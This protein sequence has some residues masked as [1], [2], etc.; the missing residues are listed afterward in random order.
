MRQHIAAGNYLRKK[1]NKGVLFLENVCV[2]PR[3]KDTEC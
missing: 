1:G 3:G 2:K